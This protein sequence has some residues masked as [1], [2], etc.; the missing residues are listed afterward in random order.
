MVIRSIQDHVRALIGRRV[1]ESKVDGAPSPDIEARAVLESIALNL[2]LKPRTV[3]Y[4]AHL[5]RNGLLSSISQE[6]SAI[7]NLLSTVDDL[8]NITFTASDTQPLEK[9][10]T[11]LLQMENLEKI[12]T[13][14]GDFQRYSR[15]VDEFLNKTLAKNVR[16]LGTPE[17]IRSNMEAAADLP[18]E[19][20]NLRNLHAVT[21]SKLN[22]LSV[23]VENFLLSSLGTI[24]G[25]TTAYRAREDLEDILSIIENGEAAQQSRDIAIR[26]IGS[27]AALKT[28]GTLPSMGDPLID[29]GTFPVGQIVRARTPPTPALAL[30][31]V[32]PFAFGFAPSAQV[33]VGATTLTAANFP[34]SGMALD[35]RACVVS[36]SGITFP[37]SIPN[38]SFLFVFLTRSAPFTG[39][40]AQA[41][42]TYLK[43][44]RVDFTVG[45]INLATVLS[46]LNT[47][48]GTEGVAVEYLG[49]G[50][51][52]ILIVATAAVDSITISPILTAPKLLDPNDYDVFTN[53][54]H[55]ALGFRLGQGGVFGTTATQFVVDAFNFF[56][57]SL[58]TAT[59]TDG[60]EVL[61]TSVGT[62]PGISVSISTDPVLGLNGVFEAFSST[63][64][65]FGEVLGV[66]EDPI[67][68]APLLDVGDIIST[69]HGT[70]FVQAMSSVSLSL[71]SPVRTFSG[72]IE[73]SSALAVAGA[74]L[75]SSIQSFMPIWVGSRFG[76]ELDV[77]DR[78]I[79]ALSG[80]VTSGTRNLT[81]E[82]LTD[83]KGLLQNLQS[84]L[85]AGPV[86]SNI[87]TEERS[88]VNGIITTLEERNYD[89]ALSLL[90]S[91][92][93]PTFLRMTGDTASFGGNA[94]KAMSDMATTDINFPNTEADEDSGFKALIK[95]PEA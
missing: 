43:Q 47:A 33:Q 73:A 55:A 31:A 91:L 13:S 69:P 3:L 92:D 67:N 75:E 71:S 41:D 39:Y 87:G 93:L 90:T 64:V 11:A 29:T 81:K 26:L 21:V 89:R 32:G 27:R 44:V 46:D 35:N 57:G 2:L 49:A 10:R 94:L 76:T 20:E 60:Q 84:S 40:V 56:F 50:S 9:A 63:L 19:F 77:L 12:N 68:P 59:V 88:I 70:F 82:I 72:N 74:A 42:G 86:P 58:V 23:G 45:P 48:L 65:L 83:L 79:A 62:G 78:A 7:D 61:L 16:R 54:A 85:A 24:L 36:D 17:L 52:R 25:L 30:S 18:T 53:S 14:G 1:A 8:A 34:Q 95:E 28:V 5:A 51:G 80:K 38:T 66:V 37:V 15:S 6:I 4:L 22:T